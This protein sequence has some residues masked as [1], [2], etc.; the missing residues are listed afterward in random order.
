[1]TALAIVGT[2][3]ISLR[4]GP[5]IGGV[6]NAFRT[7]P[8]AAPPAVWPTPGVPGAMLLAAAL[9]TVVVLLARLRPAGRRGSH[10]ATAAWCDLLA[11]LAMTDRPA[12]DRRRL[13]A[14]LLDP[15]GLTPRPSARGLIEAAESLG[16]VDARVRQRGRAVARD[17]NLAALPTAAGAS[18]QR[19]TAAAR[20]RR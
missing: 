18:G 3:W 5:R 6:E 8:L 17:R 1:V 2:V 13:A 7:P 16:D 10:L 9:L 11:E 14:K 12:T 20:A 15:L 19:R 4:N